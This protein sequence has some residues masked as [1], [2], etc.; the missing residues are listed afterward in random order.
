TT[1]Q[2]S[3]TRPDW[4]GFRLTTTRK[5]LRHRERGR[6]AHRGGPIL[7]LEGQWAVSEKHLRDDLLE[8]LAD[9]AEIPIGNHAE[10][11]EGVEVE[12]RTPHKYAWQTL[13]GLNDPAMVAAEAQIRAALKAV[14]ELSRAQRTH[15]NQAV[16]TAMDVTPNEDDFHF[17]EMLRSAVVAI[18]GI[19]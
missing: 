2:R 10:F 7:R 4:P 15:L 18:S 1:L 19:T 14:E 3:G 11:F 8:Q 16:F 12:L 13:S 17:D 6:S 9:L 5:R